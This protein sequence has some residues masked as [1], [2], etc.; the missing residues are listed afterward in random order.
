MGK[1]TMYSVRGYPPLQEDSLFQK[2][3]FGKTTEM[4][5]LPIVPYVLI[6]KRD[7]RILACFWPKNIRITALIRIFYT[8]VALFLAACE[9]PAESACGSQ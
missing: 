2:Q 6:C 7:H 3:P 1:L 5:S 4:N 8:K 9:A